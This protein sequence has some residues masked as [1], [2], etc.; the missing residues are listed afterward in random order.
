MSALGRLD[1][2]RQFGDIILKTGAPTARVVGRLLQPG[3]LRARRRPGRAGRPE[4]RPDQPPRTA[5]RPRAWLSFCFPAPTRS[6]VADAI[7][8]RMKELKSRFPPGLEYDYLLRHHAVHPAVDRGGA[9][10][11]GDRGPAGGRGR[12][13]LPPGLEGHD[14]AHDRRA[15][16]PGRHVRRH[17]GAGLQPE[18][19]DAVRAGAGHRHRR[20]RRHHGAGKH[21]AADRRPAWTRAR[22]RSRPWT[23]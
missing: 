17:G 16:L 20:G 7:K 13:V 9:Q 6:T 4:L 23:S 18:Q 3:R 14:P 15:R 21:R 5:S 11:A 19:P 1:T 12:A 10:H 8:Q 22:P 2:E